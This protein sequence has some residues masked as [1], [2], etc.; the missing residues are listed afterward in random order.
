[1]QTYY[2]GTIVK[3]LQVLKPFASPDSNL[4]YECVYLSANKAMAAI[5]IWNKPFKWMSFDVR[6]DGVPV[7]T[8]SFPGHVMEF[9]NGVSGCIYMCQGDF[10]LDYA[11]GI[12]HAAISRTPVFVQECDVVD[13]VYDRLLQYEKENT[14][15]I[16]RFEGLTQEV[17]DGRSRTVLRTIKNLNLLEEKHPMSQFIKKKFPDLWEQAIREKNSNLGV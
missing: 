7:I 11:V 16:R 1:M 3:D 5:Y 2:H 6:D 15:I 13:N 9:Y 12:K 4:G 8:E 17:H 14:L 10:I